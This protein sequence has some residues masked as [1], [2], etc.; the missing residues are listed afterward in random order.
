MNDRGSEQPTA[1]QFRLMYRSHDLIPAADRK[2]ALGELFS[3]ARSNNKAQHISGALLIS[4]DWFVQT[5]EGDEAAVRALYG[6]IKDD[7]RHD[8]VSLLAAQPISAP[9][10]ARWSMAKVAD[11]V[12]EPDTFLI[13][14]RDGISPAA[15]LHPT[16]EQEAVLDLMRSAARGN[17]VTVGAGSGDVSTADGRVRPGGA[18]SM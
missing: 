6:K 18:M 13:A 17:P 14:H 8:S 4:D 2:T 1:A 10:F 11:D 5:L 3:K 7:P 12:D 9:V 16:P 15:S